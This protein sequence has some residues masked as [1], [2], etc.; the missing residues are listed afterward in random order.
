MSVPLITILSEPETQATET[1]RE[2][3]RATLS[4][5]L[6]S[7]EREFQFSVEWEVPGAS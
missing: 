5:A 1:L 3:A 6:D 2:V 4:R 7:V